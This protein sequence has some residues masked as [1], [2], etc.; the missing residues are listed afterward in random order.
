[1]TNKHQPFDSEGG[2]GSK[3]AG[4]TNQKEVYLV[5]FLPCRVQTSC[6]AV[7]NTEEIVVIGFVR[8]VRSESCGFLDFR[9]PLT[10]GLLIYR[11]TIPTLARKIQ[12][13]AIQI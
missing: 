11:I 12:P 5:P 2:D 13:S 8:V 3:L 4:K 6:F 1:M 10:R 9:P 7:M